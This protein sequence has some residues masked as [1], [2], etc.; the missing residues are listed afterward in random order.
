[1]RI[2]TA[3]SN[4]VLGSSLRGL[5]S[6]NLNTVVGTGSGNNLPSSAVVTSL[7]NSVIV[8]ANSRVTA[9]G[10]TNVIIIGESTDGN[11]SNTATIGNTSIVKTF[12][13]GALSLIARTKASVSGL[14]AGLFIIDSEDS[15][16]PTTYNGTEWKG[17]AYLDDVPNTPTLQ[18]VTNQGNETTN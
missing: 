1:R 10:Q 13:R 8:G 18:E 12:L 6:G 15:N 7:S 16:R 2:T 11:G 17:L 5:T 3:S 14:V 4:S 9:N